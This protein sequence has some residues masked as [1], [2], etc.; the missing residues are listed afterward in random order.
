MQSF[1]VEWI[2]D[3]LILFVVISLVELI[4]PKGRMKSYVN[5]IVGILVIFVIINPFVRIINSGFDTTSILKEIDYNEEE[6]RKA[7][8]LQEKQIKD[9]Y[10]ENMKAQ[11]A[12]LIES[13]YDY[14]VLYTEIDT[15]PDKQ[16]LFLVD[17]VTIYIK[18][19]FKPE[20]DQ[21]KVEK[22]LVGSENIAKEVF[23]GQ[24]DL[25]E[26]VQGIFGIDKDKINIFI[27]RE[28]NHGG[29]GKED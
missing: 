18:D 11:T 26:L 21:I 23:Y 10:V 14:Q 1:I 19:K 20:K 3:I 27:E 6:N 28:E 15:I 13:S 5:F 17:K 24:E 8:E 22:I 29:A 9:I 4:M 2:K 16:N 25:Y 7:L 12:E